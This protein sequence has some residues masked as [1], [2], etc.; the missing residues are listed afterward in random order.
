MEMIAKGPTLQMFSNLSKGFYPVK[1][2]SMTSITFSLP[3]FLLA[4]TGEAMSDKLL[5][6]FFPFSGS[7]KRITK[8]KTKQN[9]TT[10]TAANTK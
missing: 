1:E 9:T 5:I 10:K 6:L 7:E 4:G 8:E 2:I 3:M